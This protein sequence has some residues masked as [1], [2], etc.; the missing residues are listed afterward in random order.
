VQLYR[1]TL[2]PD[3]LDVIV[4][5]YVYPVVRGYWSRYGYA[6]KAI[7]QGDAV[8]QAVMYVQSKLRNYSPEKGNGVNYI[9]KIAYR[10]IK[11][12]NNREGNHNFH[13]PTVSSLRRD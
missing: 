12:L 6:W 11:M 7:E 5:Q 2:D 9:T 13:Y 1:Q 8:N 4:E 10:R 3:V